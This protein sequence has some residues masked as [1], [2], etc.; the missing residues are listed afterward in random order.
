MQTLAQLLSAKRKEKNIALSKISEELLIKVEILEA[1]ENGRWEDLPEPTISKGFLK[2]YVDY[3][4]LDADLAFALFRRDFDEKKYVKNKSPL[5]AKKGLML[6]PNKVMAAAFAIVVVVF[7]LYL[8]VQ[9]F[10]VA[11][12]PKLQVFTPADDLT[13]STPVVEVTGTTEKGTTISVDGEFA[14]VDENGNFTRE[15]K[16]EDGKNAIDIIAT[17]KLSPQNKITKIVRFKSQ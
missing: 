17:K 7:A 2:N 10:S 5:E 8:I 3:L 13:T 14:A 15:I 12:K 9:Y 6:T 1:F 16:L 4:E 11:A